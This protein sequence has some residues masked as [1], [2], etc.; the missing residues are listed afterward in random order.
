M[1]ICC[2]HFM[3]HNIDVD[4]DIFDGNVVEEKKDNP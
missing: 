3:E 2:C 1:E 4:I